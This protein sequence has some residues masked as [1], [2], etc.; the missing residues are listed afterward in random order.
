MPRL[1]QDPRAARIKLPTARAP[2]PPGKK[3]DE[4]LP[5]ENT[6]RSLTL[7]LR[8]KITA[9]PIR[10]EKQT[11]VDGCGFRQQGGQRITS[12]SKH[13]PRITDPKLLPKHGWVCAGESQALEAAF[14]IVRPSHKHRREVLAAVCRSANEDV[15]RLGACARQ[16]SHY[17]PGFG[18]ERVRVA[19]ANVGRPSEAPFGCGQAERPVVLPQ[20]DVF[21]SCQTKP[22]LCA[23][24]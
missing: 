7:S 20:T 1:H 9:V 16:M 15:S 11:S 4:Q 2:S 19:S 3:E 22:L 6:D 21:Q 10:T 8:K 5:S 17:R 14:Q 13:W 12:L 24:A 23:C 18:G